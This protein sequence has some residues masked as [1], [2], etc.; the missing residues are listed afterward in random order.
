[1]QGHPAVFHFDLDHVGGYQHISIEGIDHRLGK[2]GIASFA[3]NLHFDLVDDPSDPR[4][5]LSGTLRLDLLG[6]VLHFPRKRDDAIDDGHP[7]VPGVDARLPLEGTLH[8]SPQIG[9]AFHQSHGRILTL[10]F[11]PKTS[12]DRAPDG[13]STHPR[14]RGLRRGRLGPRVHVVP[15]KVESAKPDRWLSVP[16]RTAG[17]RAGC[18][19]ACSDT[20]AAV[21]TWSSS[22]FPEGGCR[23]GTR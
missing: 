20:M 11:V 1:R 19:P 7:D 22:P 16:F 23:S 3:R 9:V 2:I 17:M 15:Q 8:L 12:E 13:S 4:N 18:S 10:G 5:P 14:S 21:T 6:V